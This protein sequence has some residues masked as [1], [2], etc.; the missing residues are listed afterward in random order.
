MYCLVTWIAQTQQLWLNYIYYDGVV[1]W[2][3][4]VQSSTAPNTSRRLSLRTYLFNQKT[5]KYNL[6]PFSLLLMINYLI[7]L[8]PYYFLKIL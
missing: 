8:R 1:E 3:S 7:L 2:R 6:M 5:V 4:N